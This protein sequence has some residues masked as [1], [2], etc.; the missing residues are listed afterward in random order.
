M[1]KK[2]IF[3]EIK[4]KECGRTFIPKSGAATYCS[5]ECK[6]SVKRKQES[7]SYREKHP[8]ARPIEKIGESTSNF[9]IT[10]DVLEITTSKGDV[11]LADAVDFDILKRFSW[12]VSKTGYAVAYIDGKIQKMHRFLLKDQLSPSDDV[13]HINRKKL[14]NRRKNIRVCKRA[15]NLRNSGD[16]RNK[17]GHTGVTLMKNGLYR[18][19]INLNG[20]QKH[21]G[22]YKTLDEAIQAR[23]DGETK[24]H[25][26][27]ARHIGTE[28]MENEDL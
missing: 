2:P 9:V 7:V 27:F 6:L 10:D 13:D 16:R 25:G 26:S 5:K 24:Y 21:L 18:A 23:K 12:S 8:N 20:K 22:V 11:I 28:L 15:E 4:C 1:R 3:G 17:S 19:T 14:D